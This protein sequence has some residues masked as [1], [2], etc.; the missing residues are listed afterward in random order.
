MKLIFTCVLFLALE[1]RIH[2]RGRAQ[3]KII[4]SLKPSSIDVD[5]EDDLPVMVL[6]ADET[7]VSTIH[8]RIDDNQMTS[9]PTLTEHT[10][11]TATAKSDKERTFDKPKSLEES[12][13]SLAHVTNVD[14]FLKILDA[15]PSPFDMTSVIDKTIPVDRTRNREKSLFLS[16]AA[17]EP[18]LTIIDAGTSETDAVFPRCFKVPRCGGCCG[19]SDLLAC[20][21][22]NLTIKEFKRARVHLQARS[23]EDVSLKRTS[24]LESIFVEVHEA[25]ECQCREVKTDCNPE[26]HV[27]EAEKCKCVCKNKSD[28]ED[29][30]QHK[31]KIW[32]N[33]NCSCRCSSVHK[34]STGLIFS[35]KTCRCELLIT[36]EG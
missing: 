2:G 15:N 6:E 36:A 10:S 18:Q 31:E 22:T 30:G 29:C 35:Q 7:P 27:Y 17:C 1:L 11:T 24:T 21:P 20:V 25:C 28:Q 23:S 4:D 3:T 34:C 5:D 33:K 12:L 8:A 14:D 16:Q 19:P 32:D 13:I 9:I 26:K